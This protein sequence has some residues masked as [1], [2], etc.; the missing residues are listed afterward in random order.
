MKPIENDVETYL[1]KQ[2]KKNDILCYKFTAPSTR[3]V[4]DRILIGNGKTIFLELKRPGEK[5]R[6]LQFAIH[7]R[8]REHGATVFVADTKELVN[9]V[10]DFILQ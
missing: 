10:I 3:G 4:P 9:D 5:P 7:K 1:Y 2:A 8:M 6:K